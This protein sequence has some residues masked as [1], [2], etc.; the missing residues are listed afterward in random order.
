[1]NPDAPFPVARCRALARELA[2]LADN[3]AAR[4]AR[5]R[6]LAELLR[7][8]AQYAAATAAVMDEEGA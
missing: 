7:L 3:L 4:G 1:V 2:E 6:A 8:A 5:G